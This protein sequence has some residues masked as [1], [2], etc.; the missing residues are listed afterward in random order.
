MNEDIKTGLEA[1]LPAGRVPFNLDPDR[2]VALGRRG[3]RNRRLISGGGTVLSAVALTGLIV[4]SLT[5]GPPSDP[6][7]PADDSAQPSLQA[8]PPPK[9]EPDQD[10]MWMG[11]PDGE[12]EQTDSTGKYTKAF[13][14]HFSENFPDADMYE[15]TH[16]DGSWVVPD[17]PAADT[18][19]FTKEDLSLFESF[20]DPSDGGDAETGDEVY[21]RTVFSLEQYQDGPDQ[22]GGSSDELTVRFAPGAEEED[23]IDV[24]VFQSGSYTRDSGS[25]AD[26]T[27][28]DIGGGSSGYSPCYAEDFTGPDGEDMQQ[29]TKMLKDD[30][31]EPVEAGR[32][33]VHYRD[34]GSA[35]VVSDDT[36]RTSEKMPAP[37]LSFEDLAGIATAMPGT[38]VE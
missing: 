19:Y 17:G 15:L 35:V 5:P 28:C 29:V 18:G 25:A 24:T 33:L 1:E 21:D 20:G 36:L 4:V 22:M 37:H 27:S 32:A 12:T 3:R 10:Y 38:A 6:D 8:D 11:E 30:G 26:L 7:T 23:Y 2:A 34:D 31:S 13:W 9:L 14:D 16:D